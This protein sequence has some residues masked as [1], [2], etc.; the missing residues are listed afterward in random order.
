M[1][2]IPG[3]DQ[4]VGTGSVSPGALVDIPISDE[5][6][7]LGVLRPPIGVRCKSWVCHSEEP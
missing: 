1:N 3:G 4:V 6:I 5:T 7:S 2:G